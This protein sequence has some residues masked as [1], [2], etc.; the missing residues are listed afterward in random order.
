MSGTD[1][2][3]SRP[4]EERAAPHQPHIDASATSDALEA[5]T[6]AKP[7]NEHQ[8]QKPVKPEARSPSPKQRPGTSGSL[9]I[10]RGAIYPAQR[11]YNRRFTIWMLQGSFHSPPVATPPFRHRSPNPLPRACGWWGKQRNGRRRRREE[12]PRSTLLDSN[13]DWIFPLEIPSGI[14]NGAPG[15]SRIYPAILAVF[16]IP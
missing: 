9:R 10:R 6:A 3:E 8:K 1:C 15:L 13:P 14:A 7:E 2:E 11:E 4:I 16:E 12:N 5:R